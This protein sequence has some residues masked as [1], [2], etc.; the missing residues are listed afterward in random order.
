MSVKVP[1]DGNLVVEIVLKKKGL[2]ERYLGC[3]E[4][5]MAKNEGRVFWVVAEGGRTKSR[6]RT[7]WRALAEQ[8]GLT[9]EKI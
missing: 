2:P 7:F 4:V 9:S 1:K 5:K 8:N 3:S 6:K